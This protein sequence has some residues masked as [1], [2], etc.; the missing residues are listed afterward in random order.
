MLLITCI[1]S[2]KGSLVFG[3]VQ[4]YRL[5]LHTG[6]ENFPNFSTYSK[7]KIA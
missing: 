7:H 3:N 1:I 5:H 4:G 2:K 6:K